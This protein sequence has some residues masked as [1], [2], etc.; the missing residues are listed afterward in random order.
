MYVFSLSSVNSVCPSAITLTC[1]SVCSLQVLLNVPHQQR[2]DGAHWPGESVCL[3]VSLSVCDT[4]FLAI[5]FNWLSLLFSLYPTVLCCRS[6]MCGRCT[7]SERGTSSLLGT[8]SGS[9]MRISLH[10][11]TTTICRFNNILNR[12][13]IAV[14]YCMEES[15]AQ[16]HA[17]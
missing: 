14:L 17:N 6:R 7:R 4:K 16:T 11:H 8:V 10:N 9:N 1:L 12:T 3:S 2:W 5:N 15:W 13:E